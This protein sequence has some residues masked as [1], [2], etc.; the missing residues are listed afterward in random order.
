MYDYKDFKEIVGPHLILKKLTLSDFDE[1]IENLSS[2]TSWASKLRGINTKEKFQEYINTFIAKQEKNQFLTIVS[3]VKTSN[4]VVSISSYHAATE[5]FGMVEIGYT[6]VADKWMR[7]FVNTENKYLMSNYAFET[8]KV[9]RLQFCVDPRNDK[10]NKAM[11]R[12]GAKF[13]GTLRKW[14]FIAANDEGNRNVYSILDDEWPK[15]KEHLK[16]LMT[17]Y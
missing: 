16:N 15:V 14:R 10:S 3:R 12:I 9:R 5:N 1:I 13:E 6:W 2:E 17:A 11:L 4:E 7:T 8:M